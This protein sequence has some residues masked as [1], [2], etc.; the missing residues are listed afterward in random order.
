MSCQ[1]R[2]GLLELDGVLCDALIGAHLQTVPGVTVLLV[3]ILE[4]VICLKRYTEKLTRVTKL[5]GS[6]PRFA[7]LYASY[8]I[9][10][11][12]LGPPSK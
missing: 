1:V 6:A 8:T 5:A 3:Q 12:D 2:E 11:K 10:H 9:V 7:F 4:T